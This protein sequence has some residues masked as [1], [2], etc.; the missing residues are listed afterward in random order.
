MRLIAHQ[1]GLDSPIIVVHR[2]EKG[3]DEMIKLIPG[4]T[5]AKTLDVPFS[6]NRKAD[7]MAR[8]T[9]AGRLWANT[10]LPEYIRDDVYRTGGY[11]FGLR[12]MRKPVAALLR[13]ERLK[14]LLAILRANPKLTG[15][16]RK[17]RRST[18]C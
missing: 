16:L 17:A 2:G 7:P 13:E 4:N 1:G 9:T 8:T 10:H 14:P 11:S 6:L 12:A 18:T 15:D 5:A 3:F